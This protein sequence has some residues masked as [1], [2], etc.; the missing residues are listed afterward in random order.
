MRECSIGQRLLDVYIHQPYVWFLNRHSADLGKTILSEV[1]NVVHGGLVPMMTLI[2]QVLVAIALLLLLFFVDPILALSVCTSLVVSYWV[3]YKFMKTY[4][5]KIGGDRLEANRSRFS[6]IGEVFGAMKEVKIGGLERSYLSRF[7]KPAT[8]YAKD[9][10]A[11]HMVAQ[12]PKFA[13]EA[14]G[15]GGML[16][17]VLYLMASSGNFASA[18]PIVA[19]Y[20]LAGYRLMPALQQV[21]A[22]I[23][24]LRFVGPAL[25]ALHK[26][27]I[28]LTAKSMQFQFEGKID[29]EHS[30]SLKN[31]YYTY[32]NSQKPALKNINLDKLLEDT[33][34]KGGEGLIL[35]NNVPYEGK[36]TK[37]LLKM[38]I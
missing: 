34:S 35:R 33:I 17:L 26:D 5:T 6:V 10:A 36:R 27:L 19:V 8:I 25:D 20:A 18:I 30:I 12:L 4:L 16:L 37:N 32:P 15:F 9:N 23:S 13:L 7:A 28:G 2:A 22:S 38:K 3:I 29:L 21:Y 1:T 11:A 14:I 24:Q 31:I